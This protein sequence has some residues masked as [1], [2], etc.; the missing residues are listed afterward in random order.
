MSIAV[1]VWLWVGFTN[2]SEYPD[3]IPVRVTKTGDQY[4]CENVEP[5]SVLDGDCAKTR[6]TVV[7]PSNDGVRVP[8]EHFELECVKTGKVMTLKI[9]CK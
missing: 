9:R 1:A 8:L 6:I 4:V 2:T 3:Y 7:P 5:Y